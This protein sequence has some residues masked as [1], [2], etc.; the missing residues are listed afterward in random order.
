[1]E[2]AHADVG[3]RRDFLGPDEKQR[4]G[5]F[6]VSDLQPVL[7]LRGNRVRQDLA[8]DAAVLGQRRALQQEAFGIDALDG[9]IDC[10][11]GAQDVEGSIRRQKRLLLESERQRR[12]GRE[13]RRQDQG[14]NE[15]AA[16]HHAL[17]LIIPIRLI[18]WR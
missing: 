9:Q 17:R 15:A 3:K 18:W 12:Q 4:R 6:V 5:L 11:P 2:N 1:V 13:G 10:A 8:R 14:S 16:L 7:L